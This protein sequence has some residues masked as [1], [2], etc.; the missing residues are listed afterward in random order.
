MMA[1]RLRARESS[2]TRGAYSY[3]ARDDLIVEHAEHLHLA[4]FGRLHRGHLIPINHLFAD[5]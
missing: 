1:L 4:P 2:W 3:A 5:A